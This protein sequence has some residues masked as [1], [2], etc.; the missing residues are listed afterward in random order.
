M[1]KSKLVPKSKF[2]SMIQANDGIIR[3]LVSSIN[4]LKE[5]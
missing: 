1:I 2:K 4:K 5:K 3:I